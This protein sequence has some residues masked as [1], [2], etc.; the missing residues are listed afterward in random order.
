MLL[1]PLVVATETEIKVKTVPFSEV[2]LSVINPASEK[3]YA[4]R[5]YRN[6]TNAY[7]DAL[8]THESSHSEFDINIIV[9]RL[10]DKIYNERLNTTYS[11]GQDI[12]IEIPIEGYT[13]FETPNETSETNSSNNSIENS[14]STN[15]TNSTVSTNATNSTNQTN[16]S[17]SI[18]GNAVS[19]NSSDNKN[20]SNT[21]Y[22]IAGVIILLII[23]YFWFKRYDYEKTPKIK[24]KK[25]D[26]SE[27]QQKSD[28]PEKKDSSVGNL[29]QDA[30]ERIKKAQSEINTLKKQQR[31]KEIR[32]RMERDKEELNNLS[33]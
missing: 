9:K 7:G 18:T 8:F 12:Y 32:E 5:V 4:Y 31:M 16:S 26:K 3:F 11:A 30:E 27:V 21:L 28:T 15:S 25:M 6:E 19:E 24:I 13:L 10:G 23:I 20:S 14:T 29:I 22:Y 33:K 17:T 1:L 2:H